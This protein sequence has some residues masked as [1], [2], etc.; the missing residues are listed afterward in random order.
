MQLWLFWFIFCRRR[1]RAWFWKVTKIDCSEKIWFWIFKN[2]MGAWTRKTPSAYFVYTLRTQSTLMTGY[3][4]L[5]WDHVIFAWSPRDWLAPIGEAFFG[6]TL[7][8]NLTLKVHYGD[9]G[10]RVLSVATLCVELRIKLGRIWLKIKRFALR[11]TT[12]AKYFEELD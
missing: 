9:Y 12:A 3:V 5:K 10:D 11:P 2:M 7:N 4:T 1:C 6:L 8:L